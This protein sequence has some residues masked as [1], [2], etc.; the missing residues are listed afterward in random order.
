[1]AGDEACAQA[2]KG[3]SEIAEA[4]LCHTQQVKALRVFGR[5][6]LAFSHSMLSLD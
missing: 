2:L 4:N 1:M 3:V 5:R 6:S